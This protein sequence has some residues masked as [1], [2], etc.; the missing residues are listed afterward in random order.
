MI[1]GLFPMAVLAQEASTWSVHTNFETRTSLEAPERNDRNLT[2]SLD[3]I[4]GNKVSDSERF[5]FRI[6]GNKELT[7]QQ[8]ASL[9]NSYFGYSNKFF[10]PN[11]ELYVSGEL[12]AYLPT[13]KDSRQVESLQTRAYGAFRTSYSLSQMELSNVTLAWKISGF[14]NIQEFKRNSEGNPNTAFGLGN[15]FSVD[16]GV[17]EKVSFSTYIV[18][19]Q[20]WDHQNIRKGDAFEFGNAL[21]YQVESNIGLEFGHTIGGNTFKA[22]GVDNNIK[23]FNKDDSTIYTTLQYSF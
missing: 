22:N 1:I 7:N 10:R 16:I 23:I 6:I 4:I 5:I 20:R 15:L 3:L 14:R 11:D 19:S 18:N 8:E 2:T 21:S 17:T 9:S 12:R 13:N